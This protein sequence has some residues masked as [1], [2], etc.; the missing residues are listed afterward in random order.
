MTPLRTK[1]LEL[2]P[3]TLEDHEALHG[4]WTSPGVRRFLWDD[5]VI[6]STQTREMLEE[7]TQRFGELGH[8]IWGIR[9]KGQSR[10]LGFAGY[11]EFHDPPVLEWLIG[12]H[13]DHWRKG[14]GQEAGQAMLN[15]GFQVLGFTTI[16]AST[17]CENTASVR[18]MERLGM[19]LCRQ[20]FSGGLETLFYQ[21]QPP[22]DSR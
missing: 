2:R 18:L 5:E 15:H 4:L 16:H 1:R 19:D 6:P 7:N 8:G 20:G 3:L 17:D 11:W 13:E 22:N 14:F 21:Y 12:I 9:E 10:L